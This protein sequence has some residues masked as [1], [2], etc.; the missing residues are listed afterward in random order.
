MRLEENH[1]PNTVTTGGDVPAVR[2]HATPP[3]ASRTGIRSWSL[4]IAIST[5]ALVAMYGLAYWN[6]ARASASRATSATNIE[7]TVD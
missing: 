5:A 2:P 7:K 1:L 6:E 3:V 4:I